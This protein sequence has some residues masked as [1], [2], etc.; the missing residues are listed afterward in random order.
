M[1]ARYRRR[2]LAAVAQEDWMQRLNE[3]PESEMA[4]AGISHWPVERETVS[5][6]AE[7]IEAPRVDLAFAPM[8]ANGANAAEKFVEGEGWFETD[9][10]TL[11]GKVSLGRGPS[12]RASDKNQ[13]LEFASL[14]GLKKKVA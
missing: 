13:E 3:W 7:S 2:V 11:S 6:E 10:E 1:L 14:T 9:L 5:G 8:A 12:P 4:Y